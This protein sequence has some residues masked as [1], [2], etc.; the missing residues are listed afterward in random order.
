MNSFFQD[1][2][3]ALR[4]LRKSPGFTAVVVIT[5]ALG[6]G[7]NT[8]IFTVVEAVLLRSL[9]YPHPEKI[10]ELE[11][12][13]AKR[14]S[15]AGTI[16]VPRIVDVRQQNRVFDGVAYYFFENATL[17]LDGR[18]PERI[19]GDAVSGDFWRVMGVQP[20]LG[21]TFG[22]EGD[23]PNSP[24]EAVISYGLWQRVF[25]GDREIVG[26]QVTI[27]GKTTTIVGVMPSTFNYPKATERLDHDT[28]PAGSDQVSKRRVALHGSIGAH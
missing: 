20:L 4:Q 15:H 9:P 24:N 19:K 11:D 21:S 26:R 16:G 8:A 18:L 6:I 3:F 22:N 14:A 2:Q 27:G 23:L 12:Y 17:S 25:G 28:F 7:A 13:N 5:L 1:L 10:V